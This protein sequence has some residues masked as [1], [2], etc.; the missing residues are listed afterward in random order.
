VARRLARLAEIGVT[1]LSG[2]GPR[3]AQALEALGVGS[4]LDLLTYYPRDWADRRSITTIS[5]L[6]EGRETS[7][8]ARVLSVSTRRARGRRTVVQV[9]LADSSGAR[10]PVTFFNQPWRARQLAGGDE[11]VVHGRPA[12]FRGGLQMTNPLLDLIGVSPRAQG[13]GAVAGAP[14]PARPGSRRRQRQTGRIVPLYRQSERSGIASYEIAAIVREALRRAEEEGALVDPL[15][16]ERRRELGLVSRSEAFHGIHEPAS[17]AE[18]EAA[19]R[20]LAFDELWRLQVALQLRRRAAAA[21]SRGIRHS[22]RGEL[23]RR[24][25]Q[26]LPFELTSAQRQGLR[27]IAR[28]LE[29][30]TAMHRLLQGDVGSG[31]TVVALATLLFAVDG[32]HQGALMVPTEVLAEQHLLAA[33]RL[34]SGL[35]VPDAR[36]LGGER[37]LEVALLT[38]RTPASERSRL[39]SR[40]AEGAIDIVVGTH[41]LLSDEVRFSSLG[42]AVVDEQHRFGVDQRA[43]LRE[44]GRSGLEPD[45]LVMTATPIPRT[46]AMT[47]YGDLDLTL[48]GELP[49]GRLPVRTVWASTAAGEAEAWRHVRA[50]AARGRQSYVVCPLVRPGEEP[51]DG[52]VEPEAL[53]HLE[54]AGEPGAAPVDEAPGGDRA[55]GAPGRGAGAGA[56]RILR[57]V[58]EEAERLAAGELAGLRIGVLHGQMRPGDKEAVMAAFRRGALDVLVATTVIEVGVDVPSATVVVVEDADCFGIAQLHQLR[59]RVGRGGTPATCYLFA[60]PG[61]APAAA[62]R[63]RALEE[64]ADGFE[65]ARVDLELRGEGTLLGVRQKGRNDLR[66]AS[67][68]RDEELVVPARELAGA[69]LDADPGLERHPAFAEELELFVGEEEA[70]YLLKS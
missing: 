18:R 32:G 66:L 29:R 31:K 64:T 11:V 35:R 42:V 68:V 61:L 44:K 8:R 62:R 1:E 33:L 45:L 15:S 28:D 54:A 36:R 12:A 9:L 51:E 69:V 38:S 26:G 21:R 13:S 40:L 3:V 23:V 60:A 2:V 55:G 16:A 37:P 46:A 50:E 25:V 6:V 67:L 4:V 34:L 65:L 39:T 14:G 43:A 52:E 5:E 59:G 24:F 17:E 58:V 7:V 41:A 49:P 53:G 47:L 10:L 22:T 70:A 56:A 20:R 27:E 57:S 48:L 19:R 63:L 30:P